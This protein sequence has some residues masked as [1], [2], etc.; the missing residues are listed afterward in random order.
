MYV[1]K[2]HASDRVCD[3][4]TVFSR[5]TTLLYTYES[6]LSLYVVAARADTLSRRW[7]ME[8]EKITS[9]GNP[10]RACPRNVYHCCGILRIRYFRTEFVFYNTAATAAA[11]SD[12]TFASK[13]DGEFDFPPKCSKR[14]VFFLTMMFREKR[15][16]GI[17][18]SVRSNVTENVENARKQLIPS[19]LYSKSIIVRVTRIWRRFVRERGTRDYCLS[20]VLIY[21]LDEIITIISPYFRKSNK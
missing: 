10:V 13:I 14:R 9:I 11:A 3:V 2:I 17:H 6:L 4:H 20:R 12:H 5:S 18:G 8:R 15:K 21:C 19:W 1:F 16:N 7:N